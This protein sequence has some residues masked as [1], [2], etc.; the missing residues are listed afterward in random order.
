MCDKGRGG[1]IRAVRGKVECCLSGSCQ[2]WGIWKFFY[3]N[4]LVLPYVS[5]YLLFLFLFDGAIY[6][7]VH[8]LSFYFAGF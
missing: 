6:L 1:E 2:E 7:F 3:R 5:V 4:G 8:F